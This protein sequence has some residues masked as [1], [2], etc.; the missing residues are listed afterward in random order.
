MKYALLLLLMVCCCGANWCQHKNAQQYQVIPQQNVIYSGH[1]T[2]YGYY[3][4]YYSPVVTQNVR[5][6]PIVENRIEYR[7][8]GVYYGSQIVYPIDRYDIYYPY[9]FNNWINY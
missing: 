1:A 5:M 4:Y 2:Y 7:P 6:V 8:V 3:G 9:G